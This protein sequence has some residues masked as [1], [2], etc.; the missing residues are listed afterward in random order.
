MNKFNGCAFNYSGSKAR[1]ME[2]LYKILP[3]DENLS[4]LDLFTGGGSLATQ[5]PESWSII[6]N[7][8]EH[9]LVE[10]HKTFQDKLAADLVT[11]ETLTN[12][13][14][15]NCHHWVDKINKANSEAYLALRKSYNENKTPLDLYA[16]VCSSFSNQIRFNSEEEF[17]LPK[18]DRYFNPAMEKKLLS[19]LENVLKRDITFTSK[20]FREFSFSDYD[21][22]ISDSPY[23]KSVASYNESGGW[24]F[25]DSVQLLS[26]L[27]K[28]ADSGGK[29]VMFEEIYSNGK[30]NTLVL[31]WAGKYNVTQLGDNSSN[32]N[33]QRRG[34][35]TQEVMV[36]NF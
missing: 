13:V 16:L 24:G 14:R 10:I 7:D 15:L 4:C 28:Y 35:K 36:H 5:L 8:I 18:G 26:K 30:P 2:S 9:R 3:K 1:H 17:N 34:G 31:E 25:S 32:C 19:Y 23:C 21:I 22:I 6:A 20:D 33:Y 11:P 12:I 29:F 27:D